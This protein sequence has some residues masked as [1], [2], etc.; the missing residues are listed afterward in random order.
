MKFKTLYGAERKL[1]YAHKYRVSWGKSSRSKFQTEIKNI[2]YPY[3]K[4]HIVFEEFPVVSTQLTL[5]FYDATLRVAIEVQ[6]RQHSE[7]VKFFH[8]GSKLNFIAQ[9][10]RDKE[11]CDFCEL[12]GIQLIEIH[13][14]DDIENL[15][16][17]LKGEIEWE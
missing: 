4:D 14:K 8:G 1:R 3:W 9:L 15:R 11:K 6:G 7:Y 12:N 17:F 10:K 2:L 16:K 5:D 13:D